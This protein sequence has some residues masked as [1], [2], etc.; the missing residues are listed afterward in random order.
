MEKDLFDSYDEFKENFWYIYA[1][2]SLLDGLLKRY[3]KKKNVEVL[4]LGCGTGFNNPSLVKYGKVTS[5]DL[6]KGPL[7]SCKRKGIKNLVQADATKLPFEDNTFDLV[8][9]IELMEHIPNDNLAISEIKRV[10]KPNG[11]FI[12][13]VPAHKSLWS[14]DD[15]MAHHERRYSKKE[16]VRLLSGMKKLQFGQRYSFIFLP[17]FIIFNIQKIL[18]RNR[19]GLRKTSSLDMTPGFANSILKMIMGLENYL[20]SKGFSFPI[21]IGWFGVFRNKK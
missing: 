8:A 3:I 19:K 4:D 5:V 2:R 18:N 20:I 16:L 7:E 11:V 13:T 6:L 10:L 9:A 21:G 1:R 12:F 15:E 14:S 17:S